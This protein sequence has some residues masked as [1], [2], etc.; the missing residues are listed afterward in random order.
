M[1]DWDDWDDTSERE[2]VDPLSD[3]VALHTA[4]TPE[5]LWRV[6][7]LPGFRSR[8]HPFEAVGL[9]RKHH[10]KGGPG[11]VKTALMLCTCGRWEPYTGRLIAALVNTGI[12]SENELDELVA[13]FLWSDRYRFEYPAAWF[14]AHAMVVDLDDRG[15]AQGSVVISVDPNTPVPTERRIAPPL[16]RWATGSGIRRDPGR[17][18]A[19]RTRAQTLGGQD[20]AAIVSGLLDAIEALDADTA[21]K[22]IAL[23]LNW[24]LGSVRLLALDVLAASDLVAARRRAAADPDK[25]VRAWTDPRA[26]RHDSSGAAGRERGPGKKRLRAPEAGQA[27]LFPE[28]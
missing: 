11:A 16:R 3:L 4:S 21:R 28:T 17:F 10:E 24:P 19:I 6:L 2:E 9:F 14:G 26:R 12:L 8:L 20:G 5:E 7:T 15:R 25:R 1:D 13:C 22:A 23:G 18:V 27:E